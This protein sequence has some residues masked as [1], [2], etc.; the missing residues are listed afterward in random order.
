MTAGDPKT[1]RLFEQRREED[2]IAGKPI[3]FVH[4][5]DGLERVIDEV[6]LIAARAQHLGQLWNELIDD[7]HFLSE[8]DRA[9]RCA[10]A[11]EP[12][13]LF[14]QTRWGDTSEQ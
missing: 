8:P 6:R 10:S 13:E 11:E 2:G 5:I 1:K 12:Q 9:M 14:E 7:A 4:D 3:V